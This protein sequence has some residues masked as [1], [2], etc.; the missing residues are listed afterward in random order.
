MEA[1][2]SVNVNNRF[3][4][5]NPYVYGHVFENCGT[6]VYP[7]LWVGESSRVPNL[8]GMRKDVLQKVKEVSPTIIRWPGGTPSEAYHWL[9]GIGPREER[10][11]MLLPASSNSPGEPHEFGTDEYIDFCN[12]IGADPYICVNVGTGTPEE[13]ALWL[14]YCNREGDTKYASMRTKNGHPGPFKVKIWGIGNE[15]YFW[16]NAQSYAQTVIQHARIMRWV[17]PT[18]KLVAAGTDNEW[19]YEVLKTAGTHIDYISVHPY[20]HCEDYYTLVAC[21]LEAEMKLTSL[22]NLI[23]AITAPKQRKVEIAVDEWNVWHKEAIHENGLMQKLCLMD[24]LFAA[25]MFHVFHRMCNIVTMA[26]FCDL[27][28]CLPAI[29][30]SEDDLYVNPI[31]LAFELYTKHTGNIALK[32]V[33]QVDSYNVG[34]ILRDKKEVFKVEHVPYLDCSATL[35]EEN[36]RLSISVINRHKEQDIE[37][38]IELQGFKPQQGGQVYELNAEAVTSANDFDSPNH[39]RISEKTFICTLTDQQR[40]S[41]TFPAHSATILKLISSNL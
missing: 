36:N 18:I 21:P 41:Y 32:S 15:S 13:A 17:D 5:I 29:V 33:V 25:G 12:E 7:G 8:R 9:D 37:C 1:K 19:N 14:E 26:N 11:N 22:S 39:V 6:C 3:G 2:I 40:F 16:L 24:G 38:Q 4:R 31:Y 23:G 20:Y 35:D 30:T 10:P 28:N 34:E 27:T